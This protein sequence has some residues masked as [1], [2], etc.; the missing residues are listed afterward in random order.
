MNRLR[1]L[2]YSPRWVLVGLLLLTMWVY[3]P[4]YHGSFVG[5]DYVQLDYIAPYVERPFSALALLNPFTLP[6]YYRP[7]Q[8]WW[9]LFNRLVFGLNPF[10]YYAF[11]LGLHLLAVALVYRVARQLQIRP[12]AALIATT[13]FAIHGHHLDVVAWISSMAIVSGVVFTLAAV[14]AFLSWLHH[15]NRKHL[16]LALL[17]YFLSLITHEEGFLLPPL[18]VWLHMLHTARRTQPKRRK[19]GKM[20]EK[21]FWQGWQWP[22]SG[23][24]TAVFLIMAISVIGY[25]VIQ[26]TRPNLT[27]SVGDT[28][29]NQYLTYLSPYRFSLYVVEFFVRYTLTFNWLDFLLRY[30]IAWSYLLLLAGAIWFWYGGR[31]VKFGLTWLALH[32][33]FIYWALWSQKPELFAGRHL[34]NASVGLVWALGWVIDAWLKRPFSPPALSPNRQRAIL[35][36]VLI[37]L[38]WTHIRIT[39]NTQLGWLADTQEDARVEAQMKAI[40]PSVND[41]THIFANRF[42][43]KPTFLP[44]VARVWYNYPLPNPAGAIET[45]KKHGRADR[46]YYVFDYDGETLYN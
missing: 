24:E 18:L 46:N 35:L 22:V 25:L 7:I 23:E 8:N 16:G 43:M 27:I 28:P 12:F 4:P 38:L 9:F 6:W 13:L 5:D 2:S 20:A 41:K 30:S 14:S 42:V 11:L 29:A 17:F 32:A 31:T 33:A 19:K 10:G 15:H 3:F 34:Y 37:P 44:A 36:L 39:R 45:L 21:R 1:K 26:F 40:L